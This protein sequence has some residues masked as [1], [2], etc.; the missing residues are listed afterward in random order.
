MRSA[1]AQLEPVA[2]DEL[3]DQVI[4][5]AREAETD[6]E[7]DL[8]IRR[9]VQ[10]ENG[11][12]LVLLVVPGVEPPDRAQGAVVLG[13]DGDQYRKLEAQLGARGE[14]PASHLL[15]RRTDSEA[16]GNLPDTTTGPVHKGIR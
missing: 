11:E 3:D 2:Y 12:Y 5:A 6:S 13:A 4:G 15:T 16:A 8:P 9:E 14:V 1:C 7:V 10:V